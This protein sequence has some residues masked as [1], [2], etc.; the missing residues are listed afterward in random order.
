[1]FVP[2]FQHLVKIVCHYGKILFDQIL[3]IRSLEMW[4]GNEVCQRKLIY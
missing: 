1:M 3:L 2:V 4:S